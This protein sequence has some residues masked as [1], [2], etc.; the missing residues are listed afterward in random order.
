MALISVE[1]GAGHVYRFAAHLHTVRFVAAGAQDGTAVGQDTG[2]QVTVEVHGAVL[3]ETAEAIT[4]ADA[5]HPEGVLAGFTD[6]AYGGVEAGAIAAAGENTDVLWHSV[7]GLLVDADCG[8][9]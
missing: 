5:V 9:S 8:V 7:A 3:D 1:D 6:T 4:E 2:E